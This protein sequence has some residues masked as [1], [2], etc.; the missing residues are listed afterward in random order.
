[1][2]ANSTARDIK[3]TL[4]WLVVATIVVYIASG[5]VAIIA[6][7]NA[8]N[9][10]TALCALRADVERR[11]ASTRVFLREHPE[12]IPGIPVA[13]LRASEETAMR[14]VRALSMLDC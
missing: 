3:R 14:T 9:A 12:G 8:H 1:M 6:Q 2:S 7:H 4:R 10:H 13:T 11:A 5:T